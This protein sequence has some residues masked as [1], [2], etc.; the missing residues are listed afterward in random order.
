MIRGVET[1]GCPVKSDLRTNPDVNRHAHVRRWLRSSGAGAH[2]ATKEA[3]GG[4]DGEEPE[5]GL[6]VSDATLEVTEASAAT[7]AQ[8]NAPP[9]S[10]EGP[11]AK[12]AKVA[13]EARAEGEGVALV[14]L[15]IDEA[16]PVTAA[17]GSVPP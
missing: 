14:A 13:K 5:E 15:E 2:A 4:G 16:G 10:S 12:R 3:K 11:R 9:R 6:V 8:G 17:R 1:E 7:I